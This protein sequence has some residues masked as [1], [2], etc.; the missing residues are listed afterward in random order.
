MASAAPRLLIA[1]GREAIYQEA[2]NPPDLHR[3][4]AI[5][6]SLNWFEE[7]GSFW[8]VQAHKLDQAALVAIAESL[9]DY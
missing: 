7:D 5:R 1:R 9:K 2:R 4:L 6:S 8:A 3:S